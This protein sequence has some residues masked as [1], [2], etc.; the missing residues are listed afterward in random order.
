MRRSTLKTIPVRNAAIAAA[1]MVAIMAIPSAATAQMSLAETLMLTYETNPTLRAQIAQ[2]RA[3]DEQIAQALSGYRP[4]VEMDADLGTEWNQIETND[5]TVRGGGTIPGNIENQRIDPASIGINVSQPIW[6]GGRTEA[7]VRRAENVIQASRA[8]V[9]AVEQSVLLEAA[10]AY[11]DV[12]EAQAV[13]EL[14][15]NNEE[16]LDRQLQATRDRFEVGEVTRTDVAQAESR[17]SGATA[18]RIDAEGNLSATRAAFESTVGVPSGILEPPPALAGLPTSL[19]ETIGLSEINDPTIIATEF[20]ERAAQD[21]VD[22]ARSDL[23]P[24]IFVQGTVRHDVNPSFNTDRLE[25]AAITAQVTVPLYLAGAAS[26][27]VREA[28]LTAN[29]NRIEVDEARR[30]AIERAIQSW[31][32]LITSRAAIESLIDQVRAQEIALDG[33]QQESLVG[34]RT[35]LDVLDAEQELLDARVLLVQAQRDEVVAG[36]QVLA[37]VGQLTVRD[38]S[39]PVDYYDF[40]DHYNDVRNR[41][42]GTSVDE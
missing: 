13:L 20:V 34:A 42:W 25:T 22:V 21:A 29:Q 7:D 8:Q 32:A 35:V 1:G 6:Q 17:L 24:Q 38:L 39:L 16:V 36:F 31:E 9:I 40:D 3:T 4:T 5:V 18:E 30:F 14:G 15:I 37:A 19:E 41:W 2:L 28:R 33:V 23:L 27:R 12:V 11:M 10:T 26:S